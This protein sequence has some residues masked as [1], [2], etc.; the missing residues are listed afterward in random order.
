MR[1]PVGLSGLKA[2]ELNEQDE[3][4][5]YEP[6][7]R[8]GLEEWTDFDDDNFD[9]CFDDDDFDEENQ[10][11]D[12]VAP[13]DTAEKLSTTILGF[14]SSYLVIRTISKAL[15]RFSCYRLLPRTARPGTAGQNPAPAIRW[16]SRRSSTS[17]RS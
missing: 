5:E 14:L 10:F 2:E 12:E 4:A 8:T 15:K 13:L 7:D 9:D 11:D 16:R 17:S 6:F 1:N 3:W